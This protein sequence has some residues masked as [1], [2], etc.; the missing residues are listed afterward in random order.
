MRQSHLLRAGSRGA[1]VLADGNGS[2]FERS[3]RVW[4]KE[5]LT[6]SQRQIVGSV[7]RIEISREVGHQATVLIL[8]ND[9]KHS[10]LGVDDRTPVRWSEL[11]RHLDG[12]IFFNNCHQG[13]NAVLQE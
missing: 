7:V 3:S 13:V 11:I 6:F 10:L 9:A 2:S 1:R 4:V 8:S 12:A 5:E